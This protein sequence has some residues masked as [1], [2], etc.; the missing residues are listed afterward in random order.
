MRRLI[1]LLALAAPLA[2]NAIPRS[3]KET[4][5]NTRY[6][7]RNPHEADDKFEEARLD[8]PPLPG[9]GTQWFDLYISPG[10]PNKPQID[11]GSVRLAPDNTVRYTL[12]IRS[13]RGY[14]NIT[15][16]GLY[17]AETS[18]NA[19]K[20]SS[21]KVYGYADPANNRWVQ[22]RNP[23]W[24]EIGAILNSADPVRGTLYRAFCEDG[25]PGSSEKL[26][27]RLK[28]RAG[29]HSKVRWGGR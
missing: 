17:C 7:E 22:P 20:K 19:Q 13:E 2:A 15:A 11:L 5:V 18:F 4:T 21:Y 29:I 8:L 27:A 26:A 14:D 6:L 16:E 28:E 12:N 9:S 1:V 10:Y 24:R 3:D 25:L 23:Q